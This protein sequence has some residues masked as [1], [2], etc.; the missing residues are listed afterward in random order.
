MPLSQTRP[1]YGVQS[2]S[3]RAHNLRFAVLHAGALGVLFVPFDWS[4]V[5]LAI[6]TYAV[7]MFGV[8]A[9][10]HRYFSHRAFRTTRVFQFVLALLATLS[11]QRGVL[12]WAA[13]HRDHHRHSDKEGDI[14]S[15]ARGGFWHGHMGY[16]FDPKNAATDLDRVPDLS[17]F[18]ELRILN[19]YYYVALYAMMLALYAAG[20]AGWLGGRINGWQAVF[21]GFFLST[22]VLLHMT[23]C[24]NSVCHYGG[25]GGGSRRYATDDA[26]VNHALLA[27]L[28]LGEGWHNN[29]H[30]Y[31][32]AARNGF[33]WWEI[34]LTYLLLRV[35]AVLG[36]IRDLR[37]VP[38]EVLD[39]GARLAAPRGLAG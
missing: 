31:P 2:S 6:C 11:G 15:P 21:W 12:W 18:P 30:R 34:D 7:R 5:W 32:A 39:E 16:L 26:S 29:H 38:R 17:R 33:A 35:L 8:T 37:A 19:R 4:L 22:L 25:R 3:Q 27:V 28:T 13:L 24:I 9:G 23:L 10:Y 20:E 1:R 14:H 36:V